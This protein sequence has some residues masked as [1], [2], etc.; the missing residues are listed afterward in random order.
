[1][2]APPRPPAPPTSPPPKLPP[3][4]LAA[5][6]L[7][8]A[9]LWLTPPAP[10]GGGVVWP[11]GVVLRASVVAAALVAATG[12]VSLRSGEICSAAAGANR[13]KALMVR[14]S[15]MNDS[16]KIAAA[17]E[18]AT[19]TIASDRFVQRLGGLGRRKGRMLLDV[20]APFQPNWLLAVRGSSVT[21]AASGA[22][23]PPRAKESARRPRRPRANPLLPRW[24]EVAQAVNRQF[25]RGL[26]GVPA[27]A[28]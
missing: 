19:A 17:S 2:P 8:A 5:T 12:D 22:G 9:K 15:P 10:S 7:G 23:L 13:V 14:P 18:I 3:A 26:L 24:G 11:S 16:V 21:A 28:A 27:T 25:C 4:P 1:M 6:R 20:H